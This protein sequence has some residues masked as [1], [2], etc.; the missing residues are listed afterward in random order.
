MPTLQA[1]VRELYD[2]GGHLEPDGPDLRIRVP[3]RLAEDPNADHGTRQTLPPLV[4]VIAA[5]RN[6]IL[7]E[8]AK[9]GKTPLPERLPDRQVGP[10][11][12]VA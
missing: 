8:L 12:S 4:R 2:L 6:V 10:A 7:G 9:G 5:G 1:A 11:G 3:E